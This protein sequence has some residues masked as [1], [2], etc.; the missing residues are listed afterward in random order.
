MG[1]LDPT[2]EDRPA[3]ATASLR[4]LLDLV[5]HPHVVLAGSKAMA[6]YRPRIM[7]AATSV[8]RR[9]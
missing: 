5:S 7:L 8:D 1:I 4:S 9:P 3:S 6:S 2:A